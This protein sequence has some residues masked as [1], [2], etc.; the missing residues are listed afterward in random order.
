MGGFIMQ[1]TIRMTMAFLFS[2]LMLINLSGCL[3]N[4]E[5]D[6]VPESA[7]ALWEKVDQM[8]NNLESVELDTTTK[9]I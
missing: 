6:Y 8:M 5:P 7:A 1:K 9:V 4:S 3:E 2:I